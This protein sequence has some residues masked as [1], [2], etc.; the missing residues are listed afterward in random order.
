MILGGPPHGILN[1]FEP[2]AIRVI[3]SLLVFMSLNRFLPFPQSLNHFLCVLR[4]TC[5]WGLCQM[6]RLLSTKTLGWLPV[7]LVA[8]AIF[9]FQTKPTSS[10][11]RILMI[12]WAERK[13]GHCALNRSTLAGLFGL[14]IYLVDKLGKMLSLQCPSYLFVSLKPPNEAV[15]DISLNSSFAYL[16]FLFIVQRPTYSLPTFYWP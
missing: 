1:I 16:Q 10:T 6:L 14:V 9:R 12:F 11:I 13:L 5:F 3:S 7:W 8:S 15:T 4:R 2:M